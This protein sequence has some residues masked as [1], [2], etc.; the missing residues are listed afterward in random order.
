MI[1]YQGLQV[2]VPHL[3]AGLEITSFTQAL[4][5]DVLTNG[6]FDTWTGDNPNGWTVSGESGS[7]PAI[8]EVGSGEDHTGAGT[9]SANW[10][11]TGGGFL[12]LSQAALSAG[13]WYQIDTN[14]SNVAVGSLVVN[15]AANGFIRSYAAAIANRLLGRAASTT[16]QLYNTVP[17]DVTVDSVTVKPLTLTSEAAA[18][19]GGTFAFS[20]VLPASPIAGDS[21][22]MWYRANGDTDYWRAEVVRNASNSAWDFKL[23]SVSAGIATSRISETGVGTPNAIRVVA[24][25]DDHTCSTSSDGGASW[26]QRG[27]T[28]TNSTHNTNTG[29]RAIYSSTVSPLMLRGS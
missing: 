3:R 29:M 22:Q 2:L 23:Y 1:D 8:S 12:T 15:D 27:G 17:M 16:L 13:E 5:S 21:I 11:K 7:D 4:G 25:G 6:A 19:A 10:Y 28:V 14:L 20:F 18:A 26:T 24:S 9:G